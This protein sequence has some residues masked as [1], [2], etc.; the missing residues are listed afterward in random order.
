MFDFQEQLILGKCLNLPHM[1][2][3]SHLFHDKN[4]MKIKR[5]IKYMQVYSNRVNILRTC[6]FLE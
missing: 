2:D 6:T 5:D 4:K 1:G 3:P